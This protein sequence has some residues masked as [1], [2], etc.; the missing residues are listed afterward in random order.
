MAFQK[1][2]R[3]FEPLVKPGRLSFFVPCL[4]KIKAF[5]IQ[6]YRSSGK[7]FRKGPQYPPLLRACNEV[8]ARRTVAVDTPLNGRHHFGSILDFIQDNRWTPVVQK[9]FRIL[10]CIFHVNYRIKD[11]TVHLFAQCVGKKR[12][13]AHLA[14]TGYDNHRKDGKK[15][16]KSVG[17]HPFMVHGVS[18]SFP[19]S[20]PRRRPNCPA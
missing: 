10:P 14:G 9:K 6:E 5:Q 4:G 15:P 16:F 19:V 8:L 20:G 17:Y 3:V 2:L 13:F 11:H 18:V 12:A 7:A 1:R